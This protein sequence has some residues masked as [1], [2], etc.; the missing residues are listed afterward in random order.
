MG[1]CESKNNKDNIN[2]PLTNEATYGNMAKYLNCE[3]LKII[4]NQ[5]INSICKIINDNQVSGTGF[6]ALIPFPDRLNKL[7]VLFTCN[8]VIKGNENEI[9]LIFNDKLE[10]ILKLNNIRKIYINKDKDITIIEIKEVDN[11]DIN[12]FLEIDYNMFENKDL[13]EIYK[14]I[15]I[16][17]FPFGKE[18]NL[19]IGTIEKIEDDIIK[20]KCATGKGSSGA[21]IISL[22]NFK[23][24]GIHQGTEEIHSLNI[25]MLLTN[26]INDFI[27]SKYSDNT[28]ILYNDNGRYEGEV[29]NGLREGKGIYYHNNGGRYEGDWK[30]D[31]RE[32]KGIEY[33]NNGDRYEG[34]FKND[35]IEGKGIEYYNNGERYEGD[36]K[37][38][39]YE[40]KGIYYYNNGDRYEG[41]WKND[42]I[43][44]KGIYYYNNGD[45][46]E[47]DWKNFK[48]EGK[49]ISYYNDG[50][51]Y[52]G[53][54]K[55]DKYEGKGIYYYNDGDR[56][57]G[58]Y[59]NNKR[60]G[61][62]IYYYNDGRKEIWNYLNGVKIN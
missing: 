38:G 23:I 27:K 36:W 25:G 6:L 2:G 1:I 11:Y 47:G 16:I 35:N 30:N 15:Y 19:S 24:I 53:D 20:H 56:Y 46:Y 43:E 45:R 18:S 52:E 50:E 3:N 54:F 57:E 26:I 34:D 59:K 12:N 48:R 55:N 44:G 10:K 42:N 17:H 13:N 41:D 8:H 60:E 32:G 22:N 62:G 14:S 31:K 28:K 21:P 39:K 7:P 58:Y 61:K 49:G 37:N 4:E 40:G 51:R 9:K 5:K 29:K 33:Y